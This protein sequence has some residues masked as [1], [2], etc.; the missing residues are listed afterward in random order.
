MGFKKIILPSKNIKT[1]EKF[2]NKIELVPVTYV[3]QMIKEIF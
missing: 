3:S 1:C 2:K